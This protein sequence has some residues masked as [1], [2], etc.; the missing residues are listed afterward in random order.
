V[1]LPTLS[2]TPRTDRAGKVWHSLA[3]ALLPV[4]ATHVQA[5]LWLHHTVLLMTRP[6]PTC[7]LRARLAKQ[8]HAALLWPHK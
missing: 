7:L 3:P 1:L 5:R 4:P 6:R 8:L 2:N